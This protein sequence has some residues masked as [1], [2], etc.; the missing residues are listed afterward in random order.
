MIKGHRIIFRRTN[1]KKNVME[2]LRDKVPVAEINNN[3]AMRY[4]LS[5]KEQ[6]SAVFVKKEF[7][8]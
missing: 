1:Q 7:L 6:E 3:E 8:H 2:W 4:F 5:K